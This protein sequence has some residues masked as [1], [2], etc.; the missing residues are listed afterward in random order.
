MLSHELRTPLN[1]IFGWTRMLSTGGL[2]E[3]TSARAIETIE[4]N[5]KLQ[6]RLIDDMLASRASSPA[7]S[8][9]TRIRSI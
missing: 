8:V 1:A 4:R 9:S 2:D 7:S 3:E 6:A 5:A